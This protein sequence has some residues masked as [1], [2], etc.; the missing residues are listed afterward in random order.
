MVPAMLPCNRLWLL[1][2]LGLSFAKAQVV[3][4]LASPSAW[5]PD[6]I[7]INVFFSSEDYSIL[8]G[9]LENYTVK[10]N[11]TILLNI[12]KKIL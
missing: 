6:E 10:Q 2:L 1:S 4:I 8:H 5:H 7:N 3:L 11:E 12:I 9:R